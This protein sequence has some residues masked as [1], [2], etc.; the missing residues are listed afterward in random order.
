MMNHHKNRERKKGWY[1]DIYDG[2]MFDFLK[3]AYGI[4]SSQIDNVLHLTLN[5]DW[6]SP[7]EGGAYSIGTTYL[8]IIIYIEWTD[9][10][11]RILC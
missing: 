1:F 4:P 10:R 5:A 7:F 3:D 8:S 11:K 6:F 2:S 9:L